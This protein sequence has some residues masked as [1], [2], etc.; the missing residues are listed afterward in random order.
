MSYFKIL[1]CNEEYQLLRFDKLSHMKYFWCCSKSSKVKSSLWMAKFRK[2]N[3]IY[4]VS[5]SYLWL[6]TPRELNFT[7]DFEESKPVTRVNDDIFKENQLWGT[8]QALLFH[9]DEL[10]V[11]DCK[12][13]Y[14]KLLLDLNLLRADVAIILKQLSIFKLLIWLLGSEM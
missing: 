3:S 12:C 9:D 7:S 5:T 6:Q 8:Y 4:Y 13:Y 10:S 1:T 11:S 2:R 14:S